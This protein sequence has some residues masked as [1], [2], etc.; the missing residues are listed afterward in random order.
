MD[1]VDQKMTPSSAAFRPMSEKRLESS[2]EKTIMA[3]RGGK[4]TD[5]TKLSAMSEDVLCAALVHAELKDEHTGLAGDLLHTLRKEYP[6]RVRAR[7]RQPVFRIVDKFLERRVNE[8]KLS[9]QQQAKILTRALGK[10]QL[11]GNARTLRREPTDDTTITKLVS[12]VN[13]QKAASNKE[14]GAL[15][16]TIELRPTI[17]RDTAERQRHILDRLFSKPASAANTQA[18]AAEKTARKNLPETTAEDLAFYPSSAEDGKVLLQIP[19]AYANR[20]NEASLFTWDG[21]WEMKLGQASNAS[22]GRKNFRGSEAGGALPEN[23][24]G[25]LRLNDGSTVVF[26]LGKG[27]EFFKSTIY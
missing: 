14:L 3:L 8:G 2:L 26:Y 11:D 23:L 5:I 6:E 7:E 15:Q 12:S 24:F 17:S 1:R 13:E 25:K 19:L 20:A 22:D 27:S 10:A 21:S 4:A 9:E 16:K 18:T